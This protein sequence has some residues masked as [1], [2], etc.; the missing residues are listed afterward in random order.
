M[1]LWQRLKPCFWSHCGCCVCCRVPHSVCQKRDLLCPCT[2]LDMGSVLP[3]MRCC[4]GV[5]RLPE[6]CVSVEG[7]PGQQPPVLTPP[8]ADLGT[9]T[10][11]HEQRSSRINYGLLSLA[12]NPLTLRP[13]ASLA[14]LPTIPCASTAPAVP[15]GRAGS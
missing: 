3:A 12:T 4:T 8:P 1:D 14:C 2:G 5:R 15:S 9:C 10:G 6:C 13:R 7:G 11:L